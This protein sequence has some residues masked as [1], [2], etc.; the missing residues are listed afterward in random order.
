M[1]DYDHVPGLRRPLEREP[2][3][4]VKRGMGSAAERE[5][6]KEQAKDKHISRDEHPNARVPRQPILLSMYRDRQGQNTFAC[7]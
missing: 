5:Q 4:L 2:R 6:K 3:A 7:V 1:A